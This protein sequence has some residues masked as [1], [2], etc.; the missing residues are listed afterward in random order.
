MSALRGKPQLGDDRKQ[1]LEGQHSWPA[2]MSGGYLLALHD[3]GTFSTAEWR[4][5]DQ[6]ISLKSDIIVQTY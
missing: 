1:L 3:A 2:L 5:Y 4:R 6:K